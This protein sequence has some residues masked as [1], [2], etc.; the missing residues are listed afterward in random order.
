MAQP[1]FAVRVRCTFN[2]RLQTILVNTDLS[3]RTIFIALTLKMRVLYGDDPPA[4]VLSPLSDPETDRRSNASL[5]YASLSHCKS[6]GMFHNIPPT[7]KVS[8]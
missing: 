5:R 7:M 8:V 2:V 6:Q 1:L 3:G 4:Q